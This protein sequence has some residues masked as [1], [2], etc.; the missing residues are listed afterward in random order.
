MPGN[1]KGNRIQTVAQIKIGTLPY[2][3]MQFFN[4]EFLILN[5]EDYR[6]RAK[7][8]KKEL[9]SGFHRN[10]KKESE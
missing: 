7:E 2:F 6:Q 8:K 9:D 5:E 3:L 1:K 4:F 10:D